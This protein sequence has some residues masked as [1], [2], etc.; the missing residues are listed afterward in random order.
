MLGSTWE[1]SAKCLSTRA[2]VMLDRHK[3]VQFIRR[4]IESRNLLYYQTAPYRLNTIYWSVNSLS[5][6]N[7]TEELCG[8]RDRVVDYVLSCRNTDGGFGGCKGYPSNITC[9]FNALQIL[10]IY[11]HPYHD[12]HTVE[13][14]TGLLQPGGYFHND[15]YGEVDTRINCCG[16]LSLHLL[17]L[18]RTGEFGAEGLCRPMSREFLDSIEVDVG[19]VISYTMRCCN[20]DGGYGAVEGAESHAAQVFCCVSLLRS[21]GALHLV[22]R[23]SVTR[24]IVTKQKESGGLSG[25]INKKE[26]VCYSFWAYSSLVI[27]GEQEYIDKDRLVEFILSCQGNSGGFSDR[28]RNEGDLYHLMFAL[29]GLSLTGHGEVK[30]IDPGF[31][32]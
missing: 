7:E 1:D 30:S 29:A 13:F 21:L 20:L 32:L 11:R 22:D 25:R 10:F 23:R 8:M 26:D 5:L 3:H 24:F 6:L 9:T 19:S 31:A 27:I 12:Q 14:V 28:P 16:I 15:G 4:T 17:S 2:P 18:L